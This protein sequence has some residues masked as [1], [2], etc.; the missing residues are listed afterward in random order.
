MSWKKLFKTR[1]F[2]PKFVFSRSLGSSPSS[3]SLH[4]VEHY[5][6]VKK[7]LWLHH[8]QQ[9][10]FD[11]LQAMRQFLLLLASLSACRLACTQASLRSV[12]RFSESPEPLH[13][14]RN[15]VSG[16]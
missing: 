7:I 8:V 13:A 16:E 6:Y 9:T 1:P 3:E 15:L 11:G 4:Y 2:F 10:N 12:Q 5:E 14:A